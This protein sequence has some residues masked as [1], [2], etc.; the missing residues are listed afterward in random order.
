MDLLA[1]SDFN[2]VARYGGFVRAA[3]AT[4]RPKATLSRRVAELEASLGV[5]LFERNARRARLTEEG[6]ALHERTAGLLREIEEATAGVASGGSQ[7]RGLL[8]VS[9]PLLFAQAAMGRLAAG[10]V[11]AHPGMR[12]EVTA[13][14]RAADLIE[15]RYDLVIRVNP[16]RSEPLVGRC[17]LRDRTIVAAAPTLLRPPKERPRAPS[18]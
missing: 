12:I 9:A 10:Y 8:R 3:H 17:F 4:G 15:D 16:K 13:E 5:R 1:L 2:L 14:D 7:P 18:H 11:L 6:Q